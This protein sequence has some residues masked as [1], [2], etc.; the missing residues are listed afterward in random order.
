LI[1]TWHLDTRQ[2]VKASFSAL[3]SQILNNFSG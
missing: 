3:F 2:T 1:A